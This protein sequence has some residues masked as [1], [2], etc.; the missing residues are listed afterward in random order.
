MS[1][2]TTSN[3]GRA[4]QVC[5]QSGQSGFTTWVLVL[6]VLAMVTTAIVALIF[7]QKIGYQRGFHASQE[8][9]TKSVDGESLT[10]EQVKSLKQQNEIL[11]NDVATAKQELAISLTN[12]DELRQADESLKVTSRQLQ[13]VNQV[14]ADYI[15][16]KGGMPL[17]VIGA[18]IEPLPENAF[19]Y[20]FDVAMLSKDGSVKTLRPTLTLLNDDSL[21]EVPLDPS[22]YD[23]NGIARIRG[24]F[25]MPEG[26]EP[27]QVK[28]D[29]SAGGQNS[30]NLYNWQLG[31]SVEDMP[32]SLE[33]LPEVDKNPV[34]SE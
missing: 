18:K 2:L 6:F 14:F 32:L 21:V 12:L 11:T 27:L 25:M 10:V 30:E 29:L 5:N 26:F 34:D 4:P 19:E 20:R 7:G 23:I 33:D 13:Q 1:D 17:Q 24:R 3:T 31:G 22:R 9:I 16:K 28:L 15:V 8:A